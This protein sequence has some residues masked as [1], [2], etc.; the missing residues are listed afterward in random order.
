MPSMGRGC[1]PKQAWILDAFPFPFHQTR[2][3]TIFNSTSIS[4]YSHL[5]NTPPLTSTLNNNTTRNGRRKRYACPRSQAD[6]PLARAKMCR[7]TLSLQERLVERPA[8]RLAAT[9]QERRKSHTLRRL[10]SRYVMACDHF[11]MGRKRVQ[12]VAMD[13]RVSTVCAQSLR[14]DK[15]HATAIR[16]STR[17][18]QQVP[19]DHPANSALS[20]SSSPAVV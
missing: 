20:L 16:R 15:L 9:R 17:A 14:A 12:A 8:V 4:T 18:S 11:E 13:L 5:N 3:T 19:T 1:K 2:N 7:L 6:A 10:V